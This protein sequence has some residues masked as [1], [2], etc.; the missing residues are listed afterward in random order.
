MRHFLARSQ[1]TNGIISDNALTK[2]EEKNMAD[3]TP[4]IVIL[5][6]TFRE[7][8]PDTPEFAEYSR[9]SAANGEASGGKLLGKYKVMG[10]I[11]QGPTPHAIFVVEYPSRKSA[12]QAFANSEYQA[13]IP[14][15]DIAF[16]EVRILLSE[17]LGG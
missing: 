4:C 15:R 13:I 1:A 8:G 17:S 2:H 11:G 7:G 6:G 9:R 16:Q 14:L 12:E 3:E 5:E 10:N